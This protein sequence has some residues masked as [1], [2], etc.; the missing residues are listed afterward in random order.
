LPYFVAFLESDRKIQLWMQTKMFGVAEGRIVHAVSEAISIRAA[1]SLSDQLAV[2]AVAHA[3]LRI[4]EPLA[5]YQALRLASVRRARAVW[6][7]LEVAG[8]PCSSLLCYPLTFG[9]GAERMPGFGIGSVATVPE[10]RGRAYATRLCAHVAEDAARS[11]RSLALLFSAIA[12]S[13]YQRLGYR[14][15]PAWEH[16]CGRLEEL[17]NNGPAADLRPLN[18]Q[19]EL[20]TLVGLYARAHH[21]LHLARDAAAWRLSLS[22]NPGDFFLAVGDPARGYVR[23]NRDDS[24]MLDIVELVLLDGQDELPV[25]RRLAALALGLG[26]ERIDSWLSPSE[27]VEQWFEDSGRHKTLPMVLGSCDVHSSRFWSSDYF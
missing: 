13:L 2:L 15:A 16:R 9:Y 5:T 4:D 1:T 17:A 11:S 26:R 18:P 14:I 25:L 3:A 22:Q 19:A 10:A 21:G 7:L 8:A 6:W 23:L 27:A 20:D 12:P 24:R